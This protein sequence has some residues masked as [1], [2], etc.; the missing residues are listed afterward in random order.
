MKRKN[1]GGAVAVEFAFVVPLLM[2]LLLLMVDFG[3]LM[4]VQI[5]LNSGAKEAVRALALGKLPG[6]TSTDLVNRV[7][8][9]GRA[10]AVSAPEMASIGGTGTPVWVC[11][12][13]TF[14]RTGAI[15]SSS[16]TTPT[17]CSAAGTTKTLTLATPFRWLTPLDFLGIFGVTSGFGQVNLTGK[18]ATLCLTN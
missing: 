6:E 8:A 2:L 3:R 17:V 11:E 18:A 12:A 4:Y 13:T 5:S 1:D 16:C 7:T 15:S 14:S 9:L 10:A